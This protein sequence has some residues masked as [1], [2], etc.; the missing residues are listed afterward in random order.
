MCSPTLP[1]MQQTRAAAANAKAA[2]VGATA[3][4]REAAPA[5]R[6]N[7]RA[8]RA[9][10]TRFRW[11]RPAGD[12]TEILG[13]S[14]AAGDL[15]SRRPLGY[16]GAGSDGLNGTCREQA[17]HEARVHR[18]RPRRPNGSSPRDLARRDSRQSG[19]TISASIINKP[20]WTNKCSP[21]TVTWRVLCQANSIKRTP[22]VTAAG[23]RSVSTASNKRRE[24]APANVHPSW[25]AVDRQSRM[26]PAGG[27]G[28][29]PQNGSWGAT[30]RARAQWPRARPTLQPGHGSGQHHG[31][32][33]SEDL[34]RH[35]GKHGH[36][37]SLDRGLPDEL[38]PDRLRGHS[39]TSSVGREAKPGTA[40]QHGL[41]SPMAVGHEPSGR[42]GPFL[43]QCVPSSY[44]DRWPAA[45]DA[46]PA[47]AMVKATSSAIVREFRGPG[48]PG[49][50]DVSVTG[51][52]NC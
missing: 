13:R 45:L 43:L 39:P 35:D 8:G 21:S 38:A 31:G 25:V 20:P 18:P 41:G 33:P 50:K 9:E 22:W 1:S 34:G 6:A 51:T 47:R 30:I 46:I 7:A 4:A 2:S 44:P 48:A 12:P 10:A 40:V 15:K 16:S 3:R 19:V 37:Q 24:A 27:S 42:P 52:R 36:S 5:T 14:H 11:D 26:C 28:L 17:S 32:N 49:C 29:K 23:T